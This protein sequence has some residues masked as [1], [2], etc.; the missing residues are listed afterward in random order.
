MHV[1]VW[2]E[3]VILDIAEYNFAFYMSQVK[4]TGASRYQ[5]AT[6]SSFLMR[7]LG[8]LD[9]RRDYRHFAGGVIWV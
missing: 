5:R 3:G 6:V 1:S 8:A 2:R 9:I 7:S 4:V